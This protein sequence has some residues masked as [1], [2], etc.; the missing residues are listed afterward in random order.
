MS[1]K[2]VILMEIYLFHSVAVTSVVFNISQLNNNCQTMA[3]KNIDRT[4]CTAKTDPE[5]KEETPKDYSS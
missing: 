2:I 1:C 5:S 4:Y 3:L